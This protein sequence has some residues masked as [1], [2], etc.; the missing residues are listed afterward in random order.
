MGLARD[1]RDFA[2]RAT[3][4]DAVDYVFDAIGIVHHDISQASLDDVHLAQEVAFGNNRRAGRESPPHESIKQ[5]H[6]GARRQ[7]LKNGDV[8]GNCRHTPPALR[9]GGTDLYKV[10]DSPSR[11]ERVS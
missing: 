10:F 11:S 2:K 3:W 7:T 9:P 4:P 5:R 6:K 8:L 1:Q